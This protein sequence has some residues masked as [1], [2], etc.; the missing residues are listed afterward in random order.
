VLALRKLLIVYVFGNIIM[1]GEY[2][3][4]SGEKQ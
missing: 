3:V 1:R 2:F 4:L